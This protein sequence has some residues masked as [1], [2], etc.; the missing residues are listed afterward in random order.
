[1]IS[2]FEK[3]STCDDTNRGIL[4]VPACYTRYMG[5]QANADNVEL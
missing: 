2:K 1:M 4:A 5:S 3:K